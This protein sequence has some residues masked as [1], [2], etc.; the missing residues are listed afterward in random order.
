MPS[1]EISAMREADRSRIDSR[2][3]IELA[4]AFLDCL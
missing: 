3:R 2:M 4:L 1:A